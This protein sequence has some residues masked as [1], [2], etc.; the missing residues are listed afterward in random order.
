M[1]PT[2]NLDRGACLSWPGG[3]LQKVHQRVHMN[4]TATQQISHWGRGQQEVRVGVTY[5]RSHEGFRN[6]EAGMCMTVPVLAFADY[7]KSFLLETN[8][9]KEGLGA[10]LSQKQADRQ[11][12][13]ITYGSRALTSHEKNYHSTKLE[14]L[15]LKWAVTEHFKENL[16]YQSF[17][18]WKIICSHT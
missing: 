8:A 17:V 13:L 14:F 10:V 11:Y 18:V 6:I 3:P 16:L 2:S 9:F 4:Y 7:T 12:H 5:R 15:A 1:H